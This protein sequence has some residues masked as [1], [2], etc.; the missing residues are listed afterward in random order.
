MKKRG[1]TLFFIIFTLL[2]N[3]QENGS[4]LSAERF[5]I[6]QDVKI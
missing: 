3:A 5:P 6:Y 2:A 1:F 4:S